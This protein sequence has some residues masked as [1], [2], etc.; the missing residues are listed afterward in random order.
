MFARPLGAVFWSNLVSYTFNLVNYLLRITWS[1]NW[2]AET[3][4]STP[5]AGLW[6]SNVTVLAP[7]NLWIIFKDLSMQRHENHQNIGINNVNI[8]FPVLKSV[9]YKCEESRSPSN[10]YFPHFSIRNRCLRIIFVPDKGYDA[11]SIGSLK[12]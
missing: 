9:Y 6:M 3:K 11:T 10:I 12:T 5:R 2:R 1:S 4:M 7:R 8:D